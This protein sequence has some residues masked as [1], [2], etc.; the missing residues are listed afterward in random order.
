MPRSTGSLTLFAVTAPGLS[1]LAAAELAALGA[2]GIAVDADGVEWRGSPEQLFDANLRLRTATRILVRVAEFR[3]RTFYELERRARNVPWDAF[4]APGAPFAL[5]VTSRKS[6]L[7]HEGA[8]AERLESAIGWAGSRRGAG[9]GAGALEGRSEGA[10]ERAP[11]EQ[12]ERRGGRGGEPVERGRE[13]DGEAEGE[14][15]QLFV[16]RVFRDRFTISA[17]SSGARLHRRGY[18][19]STA[20]APLRETLAAAML[21]ASGWDG[22]SPLV[23]PFCGSGTIPI[24]AA[25]MA[26][27]VAPGLAN[28]A[29]APRRYAFQDWPGFDAA[30]WDAVVSRAR[31]EILPSAGAAIHG[32]DRSG[33]AIRASR[34]NAARA[35][36]DGDIAFDARP[37]S[38]IEPPPGPGWLVTNPPYGVRVG[39][40]R[41][42]GELYSAIG[43]IARERL[44]GW[45]VALL[46]ADRGLEART[47]FAFEEALATRNGGIPVR[48]VASRV[49]G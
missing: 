48:L 7:Y 45:T 1:S 13:P 35:G 49:P 29:R 16:V 25:L 3:A 42:L 19:R 30:L 15:E 6:K 24:E 22:R 41:A 20:K 40:R 28:P 32:C 44:P 18:R 17:D 38:S 10:F 23:D 27:R 8:I 12:V 9:E 39:D 5:R 31:E 21:M 33:G 46:S 36:V 47:G 34:A 11:T 37:L 26:R 4:V 14:G 43:D 2:T